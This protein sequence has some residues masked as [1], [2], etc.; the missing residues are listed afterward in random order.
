MRS[1]SLQPGYLRS[2]L[3]GYIVESLS[4]EPFPVLYRLLATWLESFTMLETWLSHFSPHS[5]RYGA[6]F[7]ALNALISFSLFQQNHPLADYTDIHHWQ[8]WRDS[9]YI[10]IN[11]LA[12]FTL[13]T[14]YQIIRNMLFSPVPK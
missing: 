13:C 2:A 8:G 14:N 7:L 3:S 12:N 1:L 11:L 9:I 6:A 10:C 4:R 5:S